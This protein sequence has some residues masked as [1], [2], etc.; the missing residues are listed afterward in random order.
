MLASDA[1]KMAKNAKVKKLILTHFWPD[2]DYSRELD[3]ARRAFGKGMEETDILRN[4]V[5]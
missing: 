3:Q 2:H 4:S 1:V 5:I